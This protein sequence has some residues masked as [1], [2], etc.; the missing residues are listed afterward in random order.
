MSYD[1]FEI[2]PEPTISVRRFVRVRAALPD[3]WGTGSHAPRTALE[4]AR[5]LQAEGKQVCLVSDSD[6]TCLTDDRPS[7]ADL[8]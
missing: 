4:A 8:P 1:V 6:H 3:G 7:L 5:L 2:A